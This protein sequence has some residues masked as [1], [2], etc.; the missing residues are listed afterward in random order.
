MISD[1][2]VNFPEPVT[3]IGGG[4]VDRV[5]LH[6]A[7]SQA[8]NIVAADG[9]A[10]R[11]L[12]E[13]V[14]P[15]LVIGDFDSVSA[16]ALAALPPA[17]L[18]RIEE[19][20]TTDFEKCLMRIDAPFILGLG[21]IGPRAD[22]GLAGWNALVRHARARCILIGPE[23]LAFAAPPRLVLELVA[24]TRISLFPMAR[25]T[26]QS[27]GLRWPIDGLVLAPDGRIGTSNAAEGRVELAFDQPG[28][29]VILPLDC[30]EEAIR[31][32]RSTTC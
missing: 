16:Q 12:A 8:P 32:L 4:D 15:T 31:A 18:M 11:A 30:L 24:G 9:G 7:L 19:Q 23:D 27:R 20:E 5:W 14:Q 25:V 26:G 3:L 2:I 29:L 10:N 1:R 22:H 21:F 28:M 13:G 17:H 6:H